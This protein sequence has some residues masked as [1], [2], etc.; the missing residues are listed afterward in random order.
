MA[1]TEVQKAKI[2]VEIDRLVR[3]AEWLETKAVSDDSFYYS[4][5]SLYGS[6]MAGLPPSTEV[7]RK[8]AQSLRDKADF[9][10]KVS[11]GRINLDDHCK[12]VRI[13][14]DRT[15]SEIADLSKGIAELERRKKGLESIIIMSEE[16]QRLLAS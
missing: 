7:N 16:L 2:I 1:L 5:L 8:R 13:T 3:E 15:K 4:A 9:L 10:E 12:Q 6:E 11:D 14:L